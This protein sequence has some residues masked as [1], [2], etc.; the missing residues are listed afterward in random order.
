M[1]VTNIHYPYRLLQ[2][3]AN[4]VLFADQTITQPYRKTVL[5]VSGPCSQGDVDRYKWCFRTTEFG[6]WITQGSTGETVQV[7]T[8]DAGI[9]VPRITVSP[10]LARTAAD[11]QQP[12]SY[13][14][15]IQGT[16]GAD[17]VKVV[18]EDDI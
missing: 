17:K 16:S 2:R 11:H 6:K 14:L 8:A 4:T 3:A 12:L 18:V 1:G 5:V 7:V 15:I 13:V 9:A 10:G